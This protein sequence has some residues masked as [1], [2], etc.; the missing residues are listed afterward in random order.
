MNAK[1]SLL[2]PTPIADLVPR[3]PAL[4]QGVVVRYD[5]VCERTSLSTGGPLMARTVVLRDSTGH[6]ELTLWNDQVWH[7]Q[8]ADRV[9]LV[10][11]WVRVNELNGRPELTLGSRGY[12]VNLGPASG[13]G[14]V[15]HPDPRGSLYVWGLVRRRLREKDLR[16]REA[17]DAV[18]RQMSRLSAPAIAVAGSPAPGAAV[19]E[20][21]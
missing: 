12:L 14:P 7:V 9:L 2:H 5:P 8:D 1:N 11:A 10:E 6:I 15:W 19:Q 18:Q 17:R 3:R 21:P 13:R 4:V 16:A 20:A